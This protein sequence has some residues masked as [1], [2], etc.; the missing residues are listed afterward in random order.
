MRND[1]NEGNYQLV[2]NHTITKFKNSN[3]SAMSNLSNSPYDYHKNYFKIKFLNN[4]LYI[5]YPTGEVIFEDG[6]PL[7]DIAIK[8]LILRFLINA[9]G[10]KET[11]TYITYKEI[12]GGYVYYPNF[13]CRTISSFIKKYGKNLNLFE[14]R[15]KKIEASKLNLGDISYKVRFINDTYV[16]FILWEGDDELEPSG[17]ILFD[18]NISSYFN[19]EDLAVIPDIILKNLKE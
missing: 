11:K 19:A 5:K 18:S 3:V 17:N 2:L 7:C 4:T 14:E 9:N 1:L 10:V 6:Q 15:M 8:I 12:E 16:V 13:K